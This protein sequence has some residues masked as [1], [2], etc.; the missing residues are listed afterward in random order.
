MF[1]SSRSDKFNFSD[2]PGY[3]DQWLGMKDEGFTNWSIMYWAR[4]NNPE[5]YKTIRKD[6]V[7]YYVNLCIDGATEW[8]VANVLYQYY[9]DDYRCGGVK[10]KTWYR[11]KQN[12]G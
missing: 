4:E 3:Y 8:D 2:I 7:D 6:T 12:S 10:H 5:V 11:F 1:F 9:K